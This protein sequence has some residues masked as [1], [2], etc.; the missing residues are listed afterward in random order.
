M[1]NDALT[2]VDIFFLIIN[3]I[4]IFYATYWNLQVVK[5]GSFN[6][7]AI[8]VVVLLGIYFIGY[9]VLMFSDISPIT[10]SSIFRGVSPLAWLYVWAEPPKSW[11]KSHFTIKNQ[12]DQ[13]EEH[14]RKTIK[15]IGRN[16]EEKD[17]V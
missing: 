3:M 15:E 9:L 8:A 4:G 7:P 6:K 5:E 13:I 17:D 10:W 12:T 1:I 14:V 2:G 11:V 16:N